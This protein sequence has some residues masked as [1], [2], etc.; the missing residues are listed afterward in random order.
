[1]LLIFRNLFSYIYLLSH[2]H[3]LRCYVLDR[4]FVWSWAVAYLGIALG[5]RPI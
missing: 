1:M 4:D 3:L 5:N 2:T